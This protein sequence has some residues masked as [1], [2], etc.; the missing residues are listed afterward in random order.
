MD[1]S[2]P[3]WM[4][5]ENG[6][7]FQ[8]KGFRFQRWVLINLTLHLDNHKNNLNAWKQLTCQNSIVVPK[9]RRLLLF[10]KGKRIKKL[11]TGSL[12]EFR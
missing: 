10:G 3:Q 2:I 4:V 8:H 11:F 6:K 7:V 12:W 1:A 5:I 9:G